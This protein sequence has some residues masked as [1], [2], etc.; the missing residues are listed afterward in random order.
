MAAEPVSVM[1]SREAD[2][3][4]ADPAAHIAGARAIDEALMLEKSLPGEPEARR[5]TLLDR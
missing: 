5:R 3:R 2:Q 4:Q 1:V